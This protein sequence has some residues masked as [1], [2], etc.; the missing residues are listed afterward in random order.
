MH[1]DSFNTCR[2]FGLRLAEVS[3]ALP[4]KRLENIILKS[5]ILFSINGAF[6]DKQSIGPSQ[7]LVFELCRVTFRL[8][9]IQLTGKVT[10]PPHV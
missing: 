1:A 2:M 7:E 6:T 9:I 8:L 10:P 4:G 5:V 3:G